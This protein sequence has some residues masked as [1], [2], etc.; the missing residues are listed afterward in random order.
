MQLVKG[1]VVR[2]K[3]GHDKGSFFVVQRVEGKFAYLI[4]GSSRTALRPKKKNP[5]HLAVTSTVLSG[6]SLESDSEIRSVLAEFNRRLT[7]AGR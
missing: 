1:M 6:Q 4:D 7:A 2:S 5:L 3:A